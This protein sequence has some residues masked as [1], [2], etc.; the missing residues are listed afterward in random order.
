MDASRISVCLLSWRRPANLP[1]IVRSLHDL[2][3]V[4]EILV[5]NNNAEVDLRLEQPKVRVIGSPENI[6]C[7]GRFRCIAEARNEAVYTQDDDVLVRNVPELRRAFLDDP[8]RIVYGLSEWHYARRHRH[9]HGD[10]QV[11]LLGWG[12]FLRRSWLAELDRLP[13]PLREGALFKRQADVYFSLGLYRRHRAIAGDLKQLNGHS[14]PAVAMWLQPDHA[15]SW[16]LSVRDALRRAREWHRPHL[17]PRWHVV[18]LCRN[19]GCYLDECVRSVVLNEA[20][21][22]VTVVDDA[23]DDGSDAVAADLEARYDGVH[24]IRLPERRGP[25][26]AANR[27]IASRDSVFVVRLDADDRLGSGYLRAADEVLADGA[28]VAN[29]DAILFGDET[30]RWPVPE[31]ATPQMLLARNPV[32]CASAFRRGHWA[33]VGGFDENLFHLHDYDFWMRLAGVGARIHAVNGD[34][35]YYRRH[36]GSLSRSP[37]TRD[38]ERMLRAKHRDLLTSGR[39][40]AGKRF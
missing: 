5:W 30:S 18:V 2:D 19:Y 16:A 32:H 7:A 27:G 38:L 11:A 21:A 6:G 36:A 40:G 28:D 17:P 4:D 12:A 23:S 24:V 37:D 10:C 22:L 31:K 9:L 25:A 35:F 14:D 29:P 15:E 20:D 34:H 39:G 8:T 33:Q 1:P 3:F 26:G 13:A